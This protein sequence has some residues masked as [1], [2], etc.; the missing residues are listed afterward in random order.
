F[1]EGF[2]QDERYLCAY[3]INDEILIDQE[4]RPVLECMCGY[5]ISGNYES[6]LN[7]FTE[8]GSFWT[9]STTDFL[10]STDAEDLHLF[11]RGRC[12]KE[13]YESLALV[14]L[15]NDSKTIGLLQLNDKR[16]DMLTLE[17]VRFF[18]R[19]GESVGVA[20]MNKVMNEELAK[21][22][23]FLDSILNN[24]HML[25]AYMD[26]EFNFIKVNSIYAKRDGQNPSFFIGKNHF[27][28]YPNAENEE[29]F[30]QV[31]ETGEPYLVYA[32]PFVYPH[33]PE[34][35]ISYWDWSLMPI[36]DPSGTVKSLVL[37]LADV[38]VRRRMENELTQY[39]EQLEDMVKE[40]TIEL[41]NTNE[42]LQKE[43][44]ERINS[45]KDK[46]KAYKELD[47]IFRTIS[48][49]I[50]YIDREFNFVRVN[51]R[52]LQ[53]FALKKSE[54]IGEKCFNK[55]N[56]SR[57]STRNCSLELILSGEKDLEYEVS[58]IRADGS[59]VKCLINSVPNIS[60]D[61]EIIGIIQYYIDVTEK[62]E[63]QKEILHITEKERQRIG[64]DLHDI[65]GQDL[66]AIAFLVEA[67]NQKMT[68][69]E[70]SDALANIDQIGTIIGNAITQ[71]RKLTRML[72]PIEMDKGS[73][74]SALFAM[75][76]SIEEIYKVSCKIVENGSFVLRDIQDVT[77]LFYIARE[78]VNN[79]V[80]HG[81]PNNVYIYL[82]SEESSLSMI[83]R[84]DG[85]GIIDPKEDTGMGLRIMQYRSN[86]IGAEFYANNHQ[87]GGFQVE[88]R[89][90]K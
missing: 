84:D 46:I 57:C 81:N 21:T 30:R 66:T 64:N 8:K 24:T 6:A 54:V 71:T 20:L 36:K 39:R 63:I 23:T 27:D 56:H 25:V 89:L 3:D 85:Y 32:K 52:F 2:V 15:K 67:L 62:R 78:A 47:Q 88:V 70:Y 49:G 61:G 48:I 83:I 76:E 42:K 37:T 17:M 10:S 79:A 19:I 12:N 69:K 59:E 55:L 65:I 40:R 11:L 29:I 26:A 53:I 4:G 13:G 58:R 75:A 1:S 33:N 14:P 43:M 60:K 16:R 87:D 44:A 74:R 77:H 9:N 34:R 7:F 38:T 28:M 35:G 86:M 22:N 45:E 31:V 73:F 90:G 72:R 5:V 51:N 18:E 50:S 80:K 41:K 68:D 82:N